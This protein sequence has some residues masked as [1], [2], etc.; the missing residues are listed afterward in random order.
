MFKNVTS[1]VESTPVSAAMSAPMPAAVI[2]TLSRDATMVL[3]PQEGC[4]IRCR[5]G[6]LWVTLEGD[7]RDF[8]LRPG[9]WLTCAAHCTAVVEARSVTA[10]FTIH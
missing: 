4:Q 8:F 10:R 3:R 9:D 1:F 6:V 7:G 2:H 5:A